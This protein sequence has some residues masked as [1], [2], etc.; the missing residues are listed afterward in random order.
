MKIEDIKKY[1]ELK[2]SFYDRCKAIAQ[3][4]IDNDKKFNVGKNWGIQDYDFYDDYMYITIEESWAYGGYDTCSIKMDKNTFV[5]DDF[6]SIVMSE[7]EESNKKYDE[8]YTIYDEYNKKI[9]E[10]SLMSWSKL[11]ASLL[12]QEAEKNF[13][14]VNKLL[15]KN[16]H[17]ENMPPFV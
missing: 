5:S 17:V 12:L 7:I 2:D 16:P 13:R 14:I 1:E 3:L 6:E 11:D 9:K 4:H 15:N 8:I 10:F